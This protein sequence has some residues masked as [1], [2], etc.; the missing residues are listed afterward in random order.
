MKILHMVSLTLR[1][2][3]IE[4]A[5]KKANI[6]DFI[7][8]LPDGYETFVGERGTGFPVDEAENLLLPEFSLRIRQS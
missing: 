2:N 3:E 4:D 5:A 8:E 1:W 7:M 6:H